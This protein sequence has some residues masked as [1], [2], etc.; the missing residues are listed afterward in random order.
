MW[1]I[2]KCSMHLRIYVI[3]DC[4]QFFLA[5]FRAN[6]SDLPEFI[7]LHFES[8]AVGTVEMFGT[9]NSGMT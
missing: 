4:N 6:A 2:E 3:F 8:S 9:E 1:I 7:M 5:A